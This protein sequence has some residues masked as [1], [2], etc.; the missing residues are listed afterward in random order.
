[1]SIGY[2]IQYALPQ[3]SPESIYVR[4]AFLFFLVIRIRYGRGNRRQW[5]F[6]GHR[7]GPVIVGGGRRVR[8]RV[9]SLAGFTTERKTKA[10]LSHG[11]PFSGWCFMRAYTYV[12]LRTITNVLVEIFAS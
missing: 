6:T 9:R 11:M 7:K 3:H 12:T 10:R 8:Q 4:Y 1:M 2:G 5:L